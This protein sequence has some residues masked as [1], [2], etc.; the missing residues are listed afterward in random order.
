MAKMM[1][2]KKR[3]SKVGKRVAVFHGNKSK[4]QGGLTKES[5]KKNKYGRIVSRKASAAAFKRK[6]YKKIAAWGS[7]VKNARKFLGIKGFCPVGG[8]T[9]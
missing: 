5:F 8:K 2:R 4:T 1:R 9:S 3:V 6:G 7:A